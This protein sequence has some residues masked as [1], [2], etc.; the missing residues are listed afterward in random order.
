MGFA[1]F[2][3]TDAGNVGFLKRRTGQP[4]LTVNQ[5]AVNGDNVVLTQDSQ[6]RDARGLAR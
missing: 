6:R 1:H 2:A 4:M 5:V 3:G